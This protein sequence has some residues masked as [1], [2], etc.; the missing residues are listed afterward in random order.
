MNFHNCEFYHWGPLRIS[1]AFPSRGTPEDPQG[2]QG[3]ASE[4]RQ[5]TP[6]DL[7]LLL[8]NPREPLGT[9][10]EAQGTPGEFSQS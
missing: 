5:A 10:G 1:A 9:S 6:G 8:G 3:G 2:A 4:D 7:W